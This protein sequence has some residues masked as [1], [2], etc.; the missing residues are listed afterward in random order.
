VNAP[1]H[2][3]IA[4][5][6]PPPECGVAAAQWQ[7]IGQGALQF[8]GVSVYQARLWAAP[9]FDADR[10]TCLPFVLAMDYQRRLSAQ[11]IA[12]R[13]LAEM[14]RIGSFTEAQASQ[15]LPKMRHAFGDVQA[16][17]RISGQHDGQG[18][19]RFA[20]NGQLSGEWIDP[21]FAR[22]FFG[23]WLSP[24]TVVPTLRAL[25]TGASVA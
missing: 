13:S 22:L 20:R 1:Y 24:L 5:L 23:I 12:E 11:V 17:D 14:R 7:L 9:G 15:W 19:L 25:L 4:P 8:F 10:Y 16:G 21:D 6:A 2:G 18:E 3:H